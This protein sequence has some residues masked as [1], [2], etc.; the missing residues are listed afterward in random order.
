MIPPENTQFFPTPARLAVGLGQES[1]PDGSFRR[2]PLGP[3]SLFGDPGPVGSPAVAR[4]FSG[5]LRRLHTGRYCPNQG[6]LS[7]GGASEGRAVEGCPNLRIA[8]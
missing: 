8:S 1:D 2:A 4:L 3:S 5:R 7:T 6:R